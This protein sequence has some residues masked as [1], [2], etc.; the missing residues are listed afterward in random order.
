MHVPVRCLLL[1][2]QRPLQNQLCKAVPITLRL[3]VQVKVVVCSDVVRAA[4]ERKARARSCALGD[5]HR[6]VRLGKARRV[7]VNVHHLDLHSEQLQGVLQKHLHVELAARALL[8]DLL[9]VDFIGHKQHAVL[10]VDLEVRAAGIG[11]HL[12]T[13]GRQ[14]GQIQPQVLCDIPYERAMFCLLRHRVADLSEHSIREA[15]RE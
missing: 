4:F 7:V 6:D 8:T 13:A 3:Y 11:N 5:L 12:E 9:S 14:F 10:Q 15:Q 2:V 1:P